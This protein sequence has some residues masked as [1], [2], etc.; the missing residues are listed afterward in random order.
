MGVTNLKTD[1]A[2]KIEARELKNFIDNSDQAQRQQAGPIQRSLEKRI[3]KGTYDFDLSVKGYRHLAD[4]GDKLYQ[5]EELRRT[6]RGFFFSI[7]TRN[8]TARFLAEDFR[9]EN[10]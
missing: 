3:A 4:T 6:P 1:G 8:L 7:P 5:R 2:N 10:F 9:T